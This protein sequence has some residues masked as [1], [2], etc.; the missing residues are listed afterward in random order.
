MI[1]GDEIGSSRRKFANVKNQQVSWDL[2]E[3]NCEHHRQTSE[4]NLLG[5]EALNNGLGWNQRCRAEC[6]RPSVYLQGEAGFRPNLGTERGKR[7]TDIATRLHYD[8]RLELDGAFK[9][10]AVTRGPS[11]NPA[12][13]RLAVEVVDHPLVYGDFRGDHPER[14]VRRRRRTIVG[15]ELLGA[16]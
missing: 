1:V 10:W 12:D 5:P 16:C 7:G 8:L 3:C 14:A 6:R 15:S 4:L 2:A 11:L 9:S 13:K